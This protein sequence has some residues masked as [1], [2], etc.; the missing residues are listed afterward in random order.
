MLADTFV[1]IA[2]ICDDYL[3]VSLETLCVHWNVRED[4]AGATF[5]AFGS[6][7]PE[8]VIN[9]ATTIKAVGGGSEGGGDPN[10]ANLGVGA[11]I[12]SGL[13]AFLV[14]PGFCAVFASEELKLKRRPFVRDIMAYSI[15]LFMLCIFFSDGKI[16]LVEGILLVSACTSWSGWRSAGDVLMSAV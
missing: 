9:A 8:I 10:S 3:V 13:I 7:A 12:G 2:I 14:I 11:I 6:A 1:G 16:V 4:I 5:M 15:A